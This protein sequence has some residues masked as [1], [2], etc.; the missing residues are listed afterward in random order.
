MIQY[1][2]E[3]LHEELNE[4]INK[5]YQ[6]EDDNDDTNWKK[7]FEYEK[8]SFNYENKSIISDLFYGVTHTV[9]NCLN[10]NIFKH[11][12]EHRF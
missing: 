12:Y 10:C 5:E 6:I 3:V 4:N 1:L 2:L 9:T 8:K 11:N 7:K